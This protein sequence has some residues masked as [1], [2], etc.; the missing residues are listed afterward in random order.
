MQMVSHDYVSSMLNFY[1]YCYDGAN[2]LLMVISEECHLW[3]TEMGR[4]DH[5]ENTRWNL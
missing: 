1:T 2:W 4:R 3:Y 5:E